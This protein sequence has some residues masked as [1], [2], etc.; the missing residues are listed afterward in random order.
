MKRVLVWLA[1]AGSA[2][3][4]DTAP[5]RKMTQAALESLPAKLRARLGAE[6]AALGE[7]YCML[8]DRYLEMERHGFVRKGAGPQSAQEIRV[9]CVRPDGGAIHS[10]AFRRDEDMASMMYLFDGILRSLSEG[11]NADAA[12][13]MGTLAHFLEDSLSP[14]HAVAE[15]VEVHGAIERSMPQF[16][17]GGRVA[18]PL[19]EHV[20]EAA[21]AILDRCYAA[22]EQNR[23]DL[24]AMVKAAKAG[25][26][27][28]L[29]VY[30]LRAGRAAAEL[31]ADAFCTL[32]MLAGR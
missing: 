22:A 25:D 13:Y 16:S 15:P 7:I 27:R 23:K 17:L 20:L 18:R 29:D 26:E 3:A 9:Y 21:E 1:L 10:A 32:L 31:V 19:A 4:W 8:P 2:W 28:T 12:K 11:R 6:A 14:P 24:P 5:H 30:R